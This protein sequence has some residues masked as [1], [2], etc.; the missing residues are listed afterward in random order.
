MFADYED[1]IKCQEKVSNLYKVS[2]LG[3]GH[4]EPRITLMHSEQ[5]M[6]SLCR[7]VA[8]SVFAVARK[9]SDVVFSNSLIT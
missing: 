2:I 8:R 9:V 1:Y 6:N 7:I 4:V 3:T 5:S